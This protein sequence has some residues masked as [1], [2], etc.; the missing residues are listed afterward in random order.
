MNRNKKG[1][2]GEIARV[3][4]RLADA[5]YQTDGR[6]EEARKLHQEAERT[7]QELQAKVVWTLPDEEFSY[8]L[9]IATYYRG[10]HLVS[11]HPGGHIK[12]DTY[13][14]SA[15]LLAV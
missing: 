6:K 8:D 13:V 9:M 12:D 2:D 5:L 14:G 3:K 10:Y 15:K 4:R 7:R 1:D 11:S